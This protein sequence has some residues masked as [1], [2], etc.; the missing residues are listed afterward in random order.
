[1]DT[2]A[3]AEELIEKTDWESGAKDVIKRI[4][5]WYNLSSDDQSDWKAKYFGWHR[6]FDNKKVFSLAA[7]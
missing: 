4:D 3:K 2:K 1:M 5:E 7:A 6:A